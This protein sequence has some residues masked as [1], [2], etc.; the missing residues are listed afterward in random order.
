[1]CVTEIICIIAGIEE[2]LLSDLIVILLFCRY[3]VVIIITVSLLRL[4]LTSRT[5]IDCEQNA[6]QYLY[7]SDNPSTFCF[8][9]LQLPYLCKNE[10]NE[11]QHMSF[12]TIITTTIHIVCRPP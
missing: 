1:M 2:L 9:L 10:I 12:I 8:R 6:D 4:S 7:H 11:K 5:N 3:I